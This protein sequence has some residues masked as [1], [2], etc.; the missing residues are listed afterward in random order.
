[1]SYLQIWKRVVVQL[2]KM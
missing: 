2:G 1:M